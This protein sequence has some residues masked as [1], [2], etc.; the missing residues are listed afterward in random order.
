MALPFD[1]DLVAAY[2]DFFCRL[3]EP[4]AGLSPSYE[5]ASSSSPLAEADVSW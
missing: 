1:L 5:S 2:G 3:L 4:G